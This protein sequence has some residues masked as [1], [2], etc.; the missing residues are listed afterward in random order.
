M[1]AIDRRGEILDRI[2][3]EGSVKVPELSVEFKVTE[4]TIRR[5]LEKLEA[6][7]HITRTYGGAVLNKGTSADLSINIR[8]GRNPEGK[9]RIA[10]KVAELIENGD[11]IML[12]SST[13]ALFVAR[14]LKDKSRVTL[15]TNSIRIPVEIAGN[16][17]DIEVI[18]AGGTLRPTSL[19]LVGKRTSDMLDHYFVNKAII[20]CKG[21]DPAL[22]TFEPHEGEAEIKKKMRDNAELLI[23]AADYTKFNRKSFTKTMEARQI[24]IL[25]TDRQLPPES[26]EQLK[27]Q[28]V[29]VIYA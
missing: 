23:L 17:G 9:N 10:K 18:V 2:Q 15:I 5:D 21:M 7:G 3:Q 26:E 19:S 20:S 13:T 11:T 6:E 12:D 29:R 16:G 27:R 28:N 25:V 24:D 22:G 4:E 1:L 14:H 8:E